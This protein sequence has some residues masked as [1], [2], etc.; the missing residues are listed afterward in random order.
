MLSVIIATL[1]FIF[2]QL[3]KP[4]KNIDNDDFEDD[5]YNDQTVEEIAEQVDSAWHGQVQ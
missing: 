3:T 4:N 5:E 2:L 1:S